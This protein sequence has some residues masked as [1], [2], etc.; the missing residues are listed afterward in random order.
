ML[1][2]ELF[3]HLPVLS[4]PRPNNRMNL[5]RFETILFAPVH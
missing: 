1:F 3:L 4:F 5:P 2:W